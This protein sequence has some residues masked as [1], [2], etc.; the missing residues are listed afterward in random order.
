MRNLEYFE[1]VIWTTLDGSSVCFHGQPQSTS[2]E[3]F[4]E[5]ELAILAYQET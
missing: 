1:V 2:F 4:I 3:R 5:L